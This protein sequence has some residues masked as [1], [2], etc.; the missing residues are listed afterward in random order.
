MLKLLPASKGSQLFVCHQSS[1]ADG[2]HTRVRRNVRDS[3]VSS[4]TS[5]VQVC[6]GSLIEVSGHDMALTMVTSLAALDNSPYL[7]Q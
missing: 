4:F 3:V 7:A 5:I 6:L 1:S 2:I